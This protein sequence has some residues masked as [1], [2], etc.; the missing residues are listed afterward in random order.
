MTKK[1]LSKL[2]SRLPAGF[3]ETIAKEKNCSMG[4]V[5]MVL[6]G[7]R[8]NLDIIKIAIA[9]AEEYKTELDG[10]TNQIKTL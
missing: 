1:E 9:L 3:I 7:K 10:L 4:L 6:S 8:K 2:K 5:S